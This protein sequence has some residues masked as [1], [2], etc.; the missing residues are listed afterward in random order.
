MRILL[1]QVRKLDQPNNSMP[2]HNNIHESTNRLARQGSQQH[3]NK[4]R[5]DL[6]A[7]ILEGKS[8]SLRFTAI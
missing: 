4:R 6:L 5:E 3:D 2:R 7:Q 8:Y 1:R